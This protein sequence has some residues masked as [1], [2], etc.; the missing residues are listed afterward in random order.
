MVPPRT[1]SGTSSP[2]G[3]EISE[4]NVEGGGN[5]QNDEE[6]EEDEEGE[7]EEEEEEGAGSAQRREDEEE[8]GGAD[9][10]QGRE[11]RR[12]AGRKARAKK[13]KERSQEEDAPKSWDF[14][15]RFDQGGRIP[16]AVPPVTFHFSIVWLSCHSS[17]D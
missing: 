16:D 9:S 14:W 8:E 11:E 4:G 10:A 5:F 12:K 2:D 17:W 13:E 3:E 7:E 1:T 15:E 6:V